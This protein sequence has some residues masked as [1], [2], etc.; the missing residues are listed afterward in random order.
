ML[1][2]NENC[3]ITSIKF[4]PV[5]VLKASAVDNNIAT[6]DLTPN[7]VVDTMARIIPTIGGVEYPSELFRFKAFDCRISI[8]FPSFLTVTSYSG[9]K[10]TT[11]PN[12]DAAAAT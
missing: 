4:D 3:Q 7:A 5:S 6:G 1:S 2:T 8:A 10:G 11:F 12:I 9:N